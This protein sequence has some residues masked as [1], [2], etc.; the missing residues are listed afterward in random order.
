[1]EAS[2][3]RAVEV[4]DFMA[5]AKAKEGIAAVA[6]KLQKLQAKENSS[7]NDDDDAASAAAAFGDGV[8][9]SRSGSS[10]NSSGGGEFRNGVKA[11]VESGHQGELHGGASSTDQPKRNPF[12][13][14][15][16]KAD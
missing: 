3:K 15:F 5:A 1:L 11:L 7:S 2:K 4:E 14:L 13:H 6:T 9:P 10:N 8:K 16:R 12:A